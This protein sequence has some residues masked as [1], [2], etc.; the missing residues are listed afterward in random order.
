MSLW[1]RR[2]RPRGAV[3]STYVPLW[4]ILILLVILIG[5]IARA[6]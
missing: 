5:A 4:P 6:M 3:Y 2:S 1:F